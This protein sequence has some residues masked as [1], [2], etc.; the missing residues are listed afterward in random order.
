[1]ESPGVR[2][3]IES[4]RTV[5]GLLLSGRDGEQASRARGD[6][7]GEFDQY[8]DVPGFEQIGYA[9]GFGATVNDRPQLELVGEANRA[10][11]L[12]RGVG[13][14]DDRQ[15]AVQNGKQRRTDRVMTGTRNTSAAHLLIKGQ[16][17][18]VLAGRNQTLTKDRERAHQ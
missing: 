12:F 17:I 9:P 13:F 10:S 2:L 11:N 5:G 1:F 18:A 16:R 4:P 14:E 15:L 8:R 7:Q 6:S 3:H